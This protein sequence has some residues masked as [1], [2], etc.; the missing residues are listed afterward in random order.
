MTKQ[1]ILINSQQETAPSVGFIYT[2]PAIFKAMDE[3]AK[4]QAIAFAIDYAKRRLT[5]LKRLQ[6]EPNPDDVENDRMEERY[7]QFIEQ[8]QNK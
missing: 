3:Y 8:Q 2:D 5:W 4:Q 6:Q 7:N 1:E